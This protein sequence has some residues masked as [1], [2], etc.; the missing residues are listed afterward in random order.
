MVLWGIPPIEYAGFPLIPVGQM[1]VKMTFND[2]K[3]EKLKF[4]IALSSIFSVIR[5][6]MDDLEELIE[7]TENYLK[8]EAKRFGKRVSKEIEK[9]TDEEEKEEIIGWYADD[10]NRLEKVFPII[11]RRSLFL[12][13]MCKTEANLLLACRICKSA[14]N[15][16]K[17]FK[18]KG[19]DRLIN[20]ALSYLQENL[21]I[22]NRYIQTNWQFI[23]ELWTIRNA[24]VHNDGIPKKSEIEQV[25]KFCDPIPSLEVD[26]KNRIILKDGSI[27]IAHH[28]V[29]QFFMRLREEIERNSPTI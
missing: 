14:F 17:P 18:K 20:Q 28:E 27:Q 8:K 5:D 6:D 19:R 24:L 16:Q 23:Q 10:F 3:R 7:L 15:L 9:L 25:K 11:Q 2:Q 13:L 12:T 4:R 22:R 1:V 21:T 29:N 26:D